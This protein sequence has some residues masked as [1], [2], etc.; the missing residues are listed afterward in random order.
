MAKK[1]TTFA[2]EIR[3]RLIDRILRHV[4]VDD[5]TG[6]WLWTARK[7]NGGYAV[8]AV[9]IGRS[10]PVPLFVHRVMLELHKGPPP[11]PDHEAAHDVLCPF[12]HCV[13]PHHLRWATS[14]ENAADRRHPH[15][16]HVRQVPAPKHLLR[17]AA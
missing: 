9:R 3:Q 1:K 5:D 11:S 6:C 13:H 16:L 4:R 12:Q 10:H 7:N 15:R 14:R 17:A 8:M 2:D